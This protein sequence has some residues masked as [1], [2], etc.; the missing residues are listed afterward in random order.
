M[1]S[2]LMNSLHMD[3]NIVETDTLKRAALN[4]F[5]LQLIFHMRHPYICCD[6]L[7]TE[8]STAVIRE[9]KHSTVLAVQVE[10]IRVKR[11]TDQIQVSEWYFQ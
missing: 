6:N 5:C 2:K 1:T 11:V 9:K 4:T 8:R 3:E 10:Y 7:E